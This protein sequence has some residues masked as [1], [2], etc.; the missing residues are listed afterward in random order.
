MPI[1]Y[2]KYHPD[3]K[4]KIVPAIKERADHKCEWCGAKNHTLIQRLKTDTSIYRYS[5]AGECDNW[6]TSIKVVLTIAH[7]DHDIKN[8]DHA[9]LACLCQRCHL[10]YDKDLHARNRKRCKTLSPCD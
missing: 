3:W 4:S 5:N 9:N 6:R 1:D 7:L 10:L 8:N 2:K